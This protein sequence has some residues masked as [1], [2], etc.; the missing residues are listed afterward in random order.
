MD[1]PIPPNYAGIWH[2][3]MQAP[4][5]CQSFQGVNRSWYR[6]IMEKNLP[7]KVFFNLL[8]C[9]NSSVSSHGVTDFVVSA[10]YLPP[11]PYCSWTDAL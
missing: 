5:S 1:L 7:H 3:H 2:L 10:T 9:Q 4:L 6:G 8:A 11:A